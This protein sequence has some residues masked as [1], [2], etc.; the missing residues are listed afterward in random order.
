M[1]ISRLITTMISTA[2]LGLSVTGV[3]I[4]E[5]S[6]QPNP[7][8]FKAIDLGTLGGSHSIAGDINDAGQIVGWSLTSSGE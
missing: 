4:V 1:K 7:G 6:N 5:A 3:A 8:D 2:F